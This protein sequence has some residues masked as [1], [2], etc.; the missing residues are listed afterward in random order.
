MRVE[1]KIPTSGE[2]ITEVTIGTILKPSGSFVKTDEEIVE[3]ETEKVNQLLYS[4]AE[5]KITLNIKEG[6][7]V[8]VGQVIGFVDTEAKGERKEEKAKEKP[9]EVAPLH[10]AEKKK[11]EQPSVRKFAKEF[12]EELKEP[13]ARPEEVVEKKEG[14]KIFSRKK[15][16]SLRRTIAE[17]LVSVKNETAMLTTFN[18]LDMSAIQEIRTKE[19]EN[20]QKKYGVKLG[21]SSFFIKAVVSA[22]KAFPEVNSFIEG[23]EILIFNT[24]DIGMAVSTERGVFVPVIRNC[25]QLSFAEIEKQV[26]DLAKKAREG[27]VSIDALRGGTFTITNGGVFGSLLSTPILNPPQS[28]ILGIHTIV[29]R[30]VV[31]NDQIAIRPMMYLALTYDHRIIDGKEAVQF[32]VHVRDYLQDPTKLLIYK[33]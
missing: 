5:G 3:V 4:P 16:S 7:V 1:I 12:V 8:K 29:K 15:M 18:E 9:K 24:Y 10:K 25:D 17:R 32:L 28:A 14:G 20:F 27:S 26:A 23:D 31:I 22:L 13:R 30:A 11:E 19:Q 33:E 2:S 21:F 6:E